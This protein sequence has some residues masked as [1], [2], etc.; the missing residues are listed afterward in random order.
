M[1]LGHP[2]RSRRGSCFGVLARG[3]VLALGL[4]AL[5]QTFVLFVSPLGDRGLLR[6]GATV[7]AGFQAAARRNCAFG[8]AT[9]S[10]SEM[11]WTRKA[12]SGAGEAE[13]AKGT[14]QAASSASATVAAGSNG[15]APSGAA[16]PQ[17]VGIIGGG[18]AG[19]A[20]AQRLK[21]LGVP[22]V[23]FDTGKRGPGGRASSRLWRGHVV[24]HAAQ[25]V[26]CTDPAFS[27]A[28]QQLG[29]A[30]PWGADRK[31]GTLTTTG[32]KP[33][34]DGVERWVGVDG[35]GGIISALASGIDV[36]QDVWV[37][38]SNGIRA[39]ADGSWNVKQP[40][41]GQ[42]KGKGGG[43]AS[44]D[45]VVIAHNGKCADRLTSS[46]PASEVHALLRTNFADS[47]P[48]RG[49]P[50]GGTFT[51][52]SV[53]SL[54]FEVPAGVMPQDFEA[55]FV[56]NEASLRWLSSN[57]AK[58]GSPAGAAKG[59]EAW[60][61]LSSGAFGKKHKA[62][63]EFLE[64]TE[65]EREV[66][67]LLLA[68]VEKAIGL[69]RGSVGGAVTATKLQLW[70]AGLPINRWVS[71]DNADFV[72]DAEHKIGIAGDWLSAEPKRASTVEAAWLSGVR[73]AEHVAGAGSGHSVGTE[74][75]EDGGRFV[76]VDGD[77][78]GGGAQAAAMWVRAPAEGEGG[79]SGWKG[80][81]RGGGRGGG[82]RKG[83]D[84]G[85][86]AAGGDGGGS[87]GGK[88]P[89][90]GLKGKLSRGKG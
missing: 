23:V 11:R 80:K 60:T 32:F 7:P 71:K 77:F 44:F 3:S 47:L 63:Q 8:G 37:P 29:A 26:A 76:P 35:F 89:K 27:S 67:D 81:G 78:G 65:K 30:R 5:R 4:L 45:A 9:A 1:T 39:S 6:Q 75:G 24:D 54:L 72:W 36:R 55:V 90:G 41:K 66:T 14:A 21:A 88:N 34:T 42:G 20:C 59:T 12:A 73:L 31:F 52:N 85:G 83:G 51:L 57:T 69:K 50:G 86:Y 13:V 17:S 10:L 18:V 53:Y 16:G 49:R 68:A 33:V 38:P 46:T 79:G 58:F 64:G 56:E 74:L 82:Y 40:S 48:D 2:L 84:G 70:G 87:K 15:A 43:D 22:A 28:V 62:P 25:F 19:L 61:V